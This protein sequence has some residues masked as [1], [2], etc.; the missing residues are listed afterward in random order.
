MSKTVIIGGVAAG[1]GTA[2]RLRRLRED[3]EIV[4]LERGEYISYANCGL[5]YHVGDVI[6]DRES[7]LVTKLPVMKSRFKVDVRNNSEVIS[8]NKEEKKLLVREASGKEYE[9]SYDNLVLATGSSPVRPRIPGIDSDKIKT[10]WTVPDTDK[11]KE[12]VNV[13]TTK[14]AV[15]VG[16]G[17]IGLEMAENL[18]EIG[19]E[20]TIVEAQDQVMAPLDYEMALLLNK[21]I[22][23]HGVELVL[24]DGVLEFVDKGSEITTKLASGKEIKSEIVILA[25]GTRANSKLAVEAGL[26]VNERGGVVVN[27]N[28]QTSDPSIYAA[29]D[30]IEVKEFVFGEKTMVPLAGPANKQARIVADNIAGIKSVYKGTQGSSIAKIFNMAAA[31][32]GVNEKTLKK[33]GLE[34]DKDYRSIIITQN[35]HA[36]YYPDPKPIFI[37]LLFSM[38]GSKIFGA[39][40]VGSEGVDKRVDTLAVAIRLGASIDDLTSLELSYAPPFSSAKDPVNM[41]GYVAE[42]VLNDFVK[43]SDWDVL[44][45]DKDAVILDIRENPELEMFKFEDA[46]HIPL[47]VLRS[48]INEL[49]KSK[50][51]IVFCAIGVRGYNTA[52]LLAQHGFEKVE[53]YPAGTR[54]YLAIR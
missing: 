37:K 1:A 5:P 48:R 50:R 38:D 4:I 46:V 41:A 33:R 20:V 30:V 21:E 27:D 22:R 13:D 47:S 6:K 31:S 2:A 25:I 26:E 35:S 36:G 54:F 8:I 3:E 23:A 15:V 18:R 14:R 28:L 29:G 10:I 24:N 16:G 52:R 39:Q 40:V 44:E 12:L 17:F 11:I 19:L 34:K 45:K 51:Y 49:D 32:T 43:I 7:L 42:D 53:V 9:E